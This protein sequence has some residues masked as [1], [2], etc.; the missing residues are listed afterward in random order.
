MT[1]TFIRHEFKAFWRAMGTGKSIAVNIILGL[2]FLYFLFIAFGIGFYMD[3]FL[4]KAFHSTPLVISFCGIILLYYVFELLMR[5]QLQELPTLRV[6]PYLHLPVKRNTLIKYLSLTAMVSAF[7]LWPFILFTPFIVKQI[8]PQFGVLVALVFMVSIIGIT[9]FNNYLAL[10]IKRKANLNG[11]LYLII[12]VL[13]AL[14]VTADFKWHLYSIRD[15]SY[16]Y[17][18][19]LILYP[20]LVLIPLVLAGIVYY[21]NFVFLKDNLYLETLVKHKELKN[22]TTDIPLIGRFGLVG[23]LVANELKLILRNKR[24]RSALIMS[25]VF[26]F[27]GLIFYTNPKMPEY[28][29]IFAGMFMTGVFIINYGQFMY[30]WQGAH[31]DGLMVSKIKFTDFIK[32]KYLLFTGVSTAVFII[33][34]PYVYFG[35]RILLL[36]FCLYL[37][38]IGVN[39][40]IVL[41]FANRN[42]KRIDLTK[43]AAFNWEGVGATQLL[44]SFPLMLA[45]YVVYLPI[46]FLGY[47]N[48]ALIAL[49]VVGLV[50][51]LMRG[52]W[53]KVLTADF[54]KRKFKIAEGFRKK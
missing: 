45:P 30:G 39:A 37:W 11:W 40:T 41:F 16:S 23:N 52:Y 43:G 50:F 29:K 53:I 38:N 8:S 19:S 51:V 17:F 25:A 22:N 28:M 21:I 42:S 3:V 10:Y 27:Y 4:K 35:W 36:Q 34:I 14:F 7:N 6:Q 18:G 44:L 32:A 20:A 54:Y 2:F 12:S 24:P 33:T 5:L 13:L 26:I 31:F 49:A 47:P 48:A 15:I 1:S 46:K 9:I